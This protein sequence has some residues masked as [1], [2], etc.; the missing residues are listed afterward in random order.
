MKKIIIFL[1]AISML[2]SR[3]SV[4]A[5]SPM[6]YCVNIK[7][8]D[9]DGNQLSLKQSTF[10][11]ESGDITNNGKG[12][13]VE[14]SG[15]GCI[16]VLDAIVSNQSLVIST[17]NSEDIKFIIFSD[18]GDYHYHIEETIPYEALVLNGIVNLT[19]NLSDMNE[20]TLST[21]FDGKTDGQFKYYLYKVDEKKMARPDETS[22]GWGTFHDPSSKTIYISDGTYNIT[23]LNTL[24]TTNRVY[25]QYDIIAEDGK[26]VETTP[27]IED[28]NQYIM[29]IS[30]IY[31]D[32]PYY[33]IKSYF[34]YDETLEIWN[35][36][37]GSNKIELY[38]HKDITMMSISMVLSNEIEEW[39][40]KSVITIF[41][42]KT[43]LA[44]KYH[45]SLVHS[46]LHNDGTNSINIYMKDENENYLRFIKINRPDDVYIEIYDKI[47]YELLFEDGFSSYWDKL[48]YQIDKNKSYIAKV[49]SNTDENVNATTFFELTFDNQGKSIYSLL[50]FIYDNELKD[51]IETFV[52]R[53]EDSM[54]VELILNNSTEN[55]KSF[56]IYKNLNT[57]T[58][59]NT[60]RVEPFDKSVQEIFISSEE[61]HDYPNVSIIVERDGIFLSK[62]FIVDLMATDV[63]NH[64]AS[65]KIL[66][67]MSQG[68]IFN[69]DNKT[70]EPNDFVTRGEFS[71]F[72]SNALSLKLG[73]KPMTF[74][75]VDSSHELYEYIEKAFSNGIINGY[76]NGTFKADDN[77]LRQNVAMIINNAF[78]FKG[79]ELE[80]KDN[81]KNFIDYDKVDSYAIDAL[82]MCITNDIITG[83]PGNKLDPKENLTRA[84]AAVI[85]T[86]VLEILNE[87]N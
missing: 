73:E 59:V 41:K 78:K 57:K 86:R 22:G 13:S 14:K 51:I 26:K 24:Q 9:V 43:I 36:R 83:K 66:E 76:P 20:M 5:Y 23:F 63:K 61:L 47:T 45:Y 27:E 48:D 79:I 53:S 68:I 2:L 87:N 12:S 49:Y 75:D 85:I 30:S 39:Y 32:Y 58:L 1:V 67:L 34:P 65:N 10:H 54:K 74:S 29:N 50:D 38:L 70:Y 3:L 8:Y 19:Y 40:N 37:K 7:I 17:S 84:E 80:N 6:T 46:D 44:D 77:I 42:E 18:L 64:W 72:L 31:D 69:R 15:Y 52:E 60:V 28:F 71:S 81:Y 33:C 21:S 16:D 62:A 35:S 55:I 82:N 4:M 25:K 56:C 11:V